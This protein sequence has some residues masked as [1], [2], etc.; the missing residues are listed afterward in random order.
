MSSMEGAVSLI[1]HLIRTCVEGCRGYEAAADVVADPR[2]KTELANYSLERQRFASE[3]K[4]RLPDS[5]EQRE[6]PSES[7]ATNSAPA[8]SWIFAPSNAKRD[9][10]NILAACKHA[11]D[12][13]VDAYR[14]ALGAELPDEYAMLI[15][16]QYEAIQ[17]S[18][19]RIKVL[20][21]ATA[22]HWT[23]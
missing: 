7:S 2:I 22:N 20:T 11:E 19:D 4:T 8:S 15:E 10:H 13:A 16:A 21:H 1:N 17:H 5:S 3:L 23:C 18:H 9:S 14:S 6:Q 12:V